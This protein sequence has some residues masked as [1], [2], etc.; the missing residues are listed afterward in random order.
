[1]LWRSATQAQGHMC[2]VQSS[3]T[4]LQAFFDIKILHLVFS[5]LITPY[6]DLLCQ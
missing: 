4:W 2:C 5:A 1:M 6:R 3:Y